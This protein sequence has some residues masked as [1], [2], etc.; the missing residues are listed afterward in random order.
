M[1]HVPN[2][3]KLKKE[4]AG[5][6]Y[7]QLETAL[8]SQ[9]VINRTRNAREFAEHLTTKLERRLRKIIRNQ[10]RAWKELRLSI[11]AGR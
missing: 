3:T 2:T 7:P 4:W 5:S 10:E 8:K 6:L 9:K 1:T 11:T